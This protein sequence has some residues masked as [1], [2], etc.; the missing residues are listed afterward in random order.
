MVLSGQ[1][2]GTLFVDF[3]RMIRSQKGVDWK[4]H[5]LPRD[6]DYLE[7]RIEP[8]EWYPMETFERFGIAILKEVA[9]GEVES[10]RMWG[11]FSVE[12][13]ARQHEGLVVEGDPRESLMRFKVLRA[14]FFDFE[15][16][17]IPMLLDNEAHVS[18]SYGMSDLAEEAA[19]NQTMGFFERL[20]EIAGA[21]DVQAEFE[22]R[23]WAGDPQ[24]VVKLSW[25]T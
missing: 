19:S 13:L 10:V 24:T 5:L 8:T 15:A 9:D 12:D 20:L 23:S 1:V 17:E 4:A 25:K 2:K 3:V 14:S 7:Q 22:S 16:I 11:R 18:I 21:T 6:M